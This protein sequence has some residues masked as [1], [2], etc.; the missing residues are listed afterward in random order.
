MA[1]L[2]GE[3][4]TLSLNKTALD[5]AGMTALMPLFVPAGL[6]IAA[7][8]YCVDEMNPVFKQTRIGKDF[9][10]FTIYKYRTMPEDTPDTPSEGSMDDRRTQLGAKLSHYRLDELLQARN[11]YNGSMFA[12]GGGRPLISEDIDNTMEALS[13]A[14]QK[15]WERSRHTT[16]PAVFGRHQIEQYIKNY[17]TGRTKEEE[18]RERAL[19]DIEY[20][21]TGSFLTDIGIIGDAIKAVLNGRESNISQ[22]RGENGAN[23]F[24]SV[25]NGYGVHIT[26][27]EHEYWRVTL[28]VAR[29]LDN[30]VDENGV[31]DI[32]PFI[33]DLVQG[34]PI[35][36]MNID[37]AE[38]FGKMYAQLPL[39]RQKQLIETCIALPLFA[40]TKRN[41]RSLK[42]LLSIN[43]AE[44]EAF[45]GILYLDISNQRR[46]DFNRWLYLFATTG[47]LV[48]TILDVRK[49]YELGNIN[50][51]PGRVQ[52]GIAGLRASS[53]IG[54]LLMAAPM[55][56][57]KQLARCAAKGLF[58]N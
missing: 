44:A 23:M 12:V 11:I 21:Q 51:Q 16:K 25:A 18:L 45:A 10:P 55:P 48:D 5:V 30:A 57:Y 40:H 7:T 52:R 56:S 26:P 36:G 31:T 35:N 33:S 53:D 4:W 29:S 50:I 13:P 1:E 22:K 24:T 39:G 9:K 27:Q 54:R 20:A 43:R 47:Y 49:D 32:H 34:K 58:K 15:L 6:A 42:E 17:D 28:H 8:I 14:E 3:A 37:E 46:V 41:A 38:E 2:I 19:H